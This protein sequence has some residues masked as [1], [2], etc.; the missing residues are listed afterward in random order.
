MG[1]R[2][3]LP[4]YL[5]NMLKIEAVFSIITTMLLKNTGTKTMNG[6]V[7]RVYDIV[8]APIV[9]VITTIVLAQSF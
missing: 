4:Y 6:L 3:P 5:I 7:Q 2:Y 1:W 9:E 8:L